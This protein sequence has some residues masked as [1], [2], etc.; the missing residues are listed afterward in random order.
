[1]NSF[2]LLVLFFQQSQA[3][4]LSLPLGLIFNLDFSIYNNNSPLFLSLSLSLSL[5]HFLTHSLHSKPHHKAT[6]TKQQ[7]Q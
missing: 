7:K 5:F 1:M 4:L 2:S 6:N 3:L